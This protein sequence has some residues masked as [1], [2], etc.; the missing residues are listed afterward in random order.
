MS[1][2]RKVNRDA[3]YQSVYDDYMDTILTMPEIA[4]KYDIS[5][6][7]IYNIK[8][9]IEKG[10]LEKGIELQK[11][12]GCDTSNTIFKESYTD[13]KTQQFV[14]KPEIRK[15][16]EIR[17]MGK[18]VI[19]PVV[20]MDSV[21]QQITQKQ[22]NVQQPAY[23]PTKA[24]RQRQDGLAELCDRQWELY[25]TK[26]SPIQDTQTAYAD[27]ID[28]P[29]YKHVETVK[30]TSVPVRSEPVLTRQQKPVPVRSEPVL[31]RQE[32]PVP[33]RSE[34]KKTTR[35]N[36]KINIQTK[37]VQKEEIDDPNKKNKRK[38]IGQDA[39]AFLENHRKMIEDRELDESE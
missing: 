37:K 6:K 22:T 12:P 1:G 27:D 4:K 3:F 8:E 7:T 38:R 29:I 35:V 18:C 2:R 34:P 14:E 16:R 21:T 23:F 17:R 39:L 26:Y 25:N 19:Q 13:E 28:V 10:Q 36:E 24:S 31:I 15:I 32:N 9:R 20:Y 5:L 33:V 30:H 11:K